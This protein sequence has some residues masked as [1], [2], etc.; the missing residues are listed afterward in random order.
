MVTGGPVKLS[1]T[2]VSV[3]LKRKWDDILLHP[4]KFQTLSSCEQKHLFWIQS[5]LF[6]LFSL[7]GT[8][9]YMNKFDLGY[10]SN[11]HKQN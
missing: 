5:W 1:N 7:C 2:Y 11:Q 8:T 6:Q 9:V 4:A 10:K 3:A